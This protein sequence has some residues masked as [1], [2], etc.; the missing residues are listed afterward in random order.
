LPHIVTT[1]SP[2]QTQALAEKLVPFLKPGDVISLTGDL[3]AGKTCFVQGLAHGLKIKNH[4]TSPTFNIIK[5][6]AGLLPLYHF[7]VYRFKSAEQLIELGYEEY[8]FGE[9]VSVIEWG[10]KISKLLPSDYLEIEFR[11]PGEETRELKILPHGFCWEKTTKRWL[12]DV[13]IGI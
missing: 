5:E 4:V 11:D 6:Y 8:F 10:D 1:Y 12:S 3:G 13:S 9:G 7:D 2:A